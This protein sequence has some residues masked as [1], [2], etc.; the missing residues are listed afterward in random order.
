[1]YSFAA[2]IDLSHRVGLIVQGS[3]GLTTGNPPG[4]M[5][6][7]TGSGSAPWINMDNSKGVWLRDVQLVHSNAGYSGTYVKCGNPGGSDPA[8]CGVE[9]CTFGSG[10]PAFPPQLGIDLDTSIEFTVNGCNFI[11][12]TCAIQGARS[13]TSYANGICVRDCQFAYGAQPAIQGGGEAWSIEGRCVFE[14]LGTPGFPAGAI[15]CTN[16]ASFRG[17][18]VTGV[19]CGD[20]GVGIGTWFD[21]AGRA[22]HFA[23]NLIGGGAGTTAFI[24]RGVSGGV[25]VGNEFYGGAVAINLA[26]APSAGLV[27]KGN[28]CSAVT[29]PWV[30]QGN[31]TG[32]NEFTP[33]VGM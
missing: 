10:D 9:R 1:V 15:L 28:T 33:N 30:N 23:G 32:A 26:G 29:T 20:T 25:I 27:V 4:T 3:G 18:T 5:L 19:W 31:V 11:A 24:L 16:G 22:L 8:F 2:P 14:N 7:Y 21:V 17:L 12:N 13:A 6:V